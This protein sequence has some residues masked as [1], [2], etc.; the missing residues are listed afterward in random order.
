MLRLVKLTSFAVTALL[1][2][3]GLAGMAQAEK[4]VLADFEQLGV[5]ADGSLPDWVLKEAGTK[6]VLTSD[7]QLVSQGNRALQVFMTVTKDQN[8]AMLQLLTHGANWSDLTGLYVDVYNPLE[9]SVD[10]IVAIQTANWDWKEF[11]SIT[12]DPGWNRDVYISFNQPFWKSSATGW[13]YTSVLTDKEEVNGL[14]FMFVVY[15]AGDC[16]FAID[17]IR[18]ER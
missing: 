17:N 14:N 3:A 5:A 12:L 16:M 6:L 9:E 13:A 11:A 1:L 7:P 8:R 10:L 2:I 18:V 4:V 15:N